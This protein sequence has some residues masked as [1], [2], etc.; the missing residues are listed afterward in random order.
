[1]EG[2]G[3]RGGGWKGGSEGGEGGGQK[4]YLF[5][6]IGLTNFVM[7]TAPVLTSLH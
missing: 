2:G 4:L 1:M 7:A 5:S 3:G 6:T